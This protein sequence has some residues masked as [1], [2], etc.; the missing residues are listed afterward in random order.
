M[1]KRECVRKGETEREGD[2]VCVGGWQ[3]EEREREREREREHDL[4][5][6]G[7]TVNLGVREA[8]RT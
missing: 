4:R 3:R 6:A 8:K 5:R 2:C 7:S 1:T